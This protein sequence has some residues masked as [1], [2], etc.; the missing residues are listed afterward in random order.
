MDPKEA[1]VK[2]KAGTALLLASIAS[3]VLIGVGSRTLALPRGDAAIIDVGGGQELVGF[4]GS[5]LLLPLP[6][7]TRRADL[8]VIGTA[9]GDTVQPFTA[10]VGISSALRSDPSYLSGAY[11]DLTFHVIE[12][13]KGSGPDGLSIRRR[14]STQTQVVVTEE[15]TPLMA[16]RQYVLFLEKGV[17]LWTGGYYPIGTQAVGVVNGSSA[18]FPTRIGTVAISQLRQVA[19]DNAQPP[20]R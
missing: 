7:L 18:T 8:V 10:N 4:M 14:A 5:Q 13:L 6:E 15:V 17:G 3:V 16:G 20:Q 11:H 9:V 2:M 12:Y 1:I 19:R